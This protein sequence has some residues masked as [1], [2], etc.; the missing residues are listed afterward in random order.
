SVQPANS[1][2]KPPVETSEQRLAPMVMAVNSP[3]VTVQ[4]DGKHQRRVSVNKASS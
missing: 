1:S 3:T 2:P 4:E